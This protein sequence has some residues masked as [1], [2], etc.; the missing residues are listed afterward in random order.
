MTPK[1]GL[2]PSSGMSMEGTYLLSMR[3][4]VWRRREP[5]LG[6]RTEREN[7]VVDA[8]GKGTSGEPVRPKYRCGGQ[9]R[10]AS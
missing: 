3:C 4:P 9:G 2:L 6:F 5:A 10:T 7:L 1:P 8:K